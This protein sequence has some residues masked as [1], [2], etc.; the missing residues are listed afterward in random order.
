MGAFG[1]L[2]RPSGRR[3]VVAANSEAG[4]AMGDDAWSSPAP[5]RRKCSRSP[6]RKSAPNRRLVPAAT[7]ACEGELPAATLIVFCKLRDVS[8]VVLPKGVRLP[9]DPTR[10]V[11]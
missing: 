10:R 11:V 1:L 5:S 7:R 6:P 9:T 3:G 2:Q 4:S 8:L